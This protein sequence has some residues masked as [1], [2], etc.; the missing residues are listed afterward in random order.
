MKIF[1]NKSQFSEVRLNAASHLDPDFAVVLITGQNCASK[2]KCHLG[3]LSL[4]YKE[5][6]LLEPRFV[7]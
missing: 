3:P 2:E 4:L 6:K 5:N 7:H 1:G